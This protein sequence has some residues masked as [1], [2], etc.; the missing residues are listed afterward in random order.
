[1]EN[2]SSESLCTYVSPDHRACRRPIVI[3][4][5][6][7]FHTPINEDE[8]VDER[9][10]DEPIVDLLADLVSKSDGDWVGFIFPKNL[11]LPFDLKTSELAFRIDARFSKFSG[12]TLNNII[13]KAEMVVDDAVFDGD[14]TAKGA[15]FENG[16]SVSRGKFLANSIFQNI[17][18][19]SHLN[20]NSTIFKS[21]FKINGSIYGSANFNEA[22]FEGTATFLDA[23]NLNVSVGGVESGAS[24]VGLDAAV[25]LSNSARESRLSFLKETIKKIYSDLIQV[26]KS[27]GHKLLKLCAV[28]S[29]ALKSTYGKFRRKFP[30]KDDSVLIEVL[31][32]GDAHFEN[33][34]FKDAKNTLFKGVDLRRA[35]FLRTDVRDVKFI[36]NSWY[37]KDLKRNGL[38]DEVWLLSCDYNTKKNLFSVLEYTYRYVRLSLEGVKDYMS[39]NDF[40]IG[41]MDTVR[42]QASF[43]KRHFF[44]ITAMYNYLSRYGT[45]PW[46][47]TGW[48]LCLVITHVFLVCKYVDP[49]FVVRI[50]A[51]EL[52]DFRKMDFGAINL[53]IEN[54]SFLS[55]RVVD[56]ALYSLQVMTLQKSNPIFDFK[57]Q[58]IDVVVKRV[59][60]LFSL[61]GPAVV[62]MFVLAF[63]ARMKR[64]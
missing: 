41:E 39:A 35:R 57:D 42:K 48:M 43:F 50:S 2:I 52:I 8:D 46:R 30:H 14:F 28:A 37:Q 17:K 40:Y 59:N 27:T 53:A 9:G 1:M 58:D 45:S 26:W 19:S 31:F 7:P 21:S 12:V 47:I 5:T 23:R 49:Q 64:H 13:F 29:G 6:C 11:T 63:R 32:Y 56:L 10:S 20:C 4:R 3:G 34:T 51:Y 54:F 60:L 16:F 62:A 15:R 18:I 25:V 22:V 55:K 36:G 38:Y 61:L 24:F 44:S 33:V